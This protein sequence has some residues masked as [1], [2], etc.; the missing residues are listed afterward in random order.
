MT[1]SLDGKVIVVTGSGQGLGRD[2]ALGLGAAGAR[3]VVNDIGAALDGH[4]TNDSVAEFVVKEIE[5]AGGM[6]TA[7]HHSVASWD[8]G[9]AIVQTALD[10]FGR[11]DGVVNNAGII[12]DRMFFSMSEDDWRSVIDVHLHGSF[13]VSRAAAPHFRA[14]GSGTFVHMTSTAGLI[15]TFGQANYGTAKMAM[16]GLSHQIAMD[17][18]RYGVVSNCVAPFAWTR[19]TS[20]LPDETPEQRERVEKMKRMK[21]ETVAPLTTYLSSDAAADVT[22]QVFCVRANEIFLFSQPRP[23]RGLHAD[24][25]WTAATIAERLVPAFRPWFV[26]I[27]QSNDVFTWDPI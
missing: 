12:R 17:M 11:I 26:P 21:G 1:T 20:S 10:A 4:G 23:L 8:G 24:A 2:L 22:G 7:D 15:G 9:Q 13:F 18:R 27:E 5:A 6:A 14:Q 25:G 16:V 19:M 3:V